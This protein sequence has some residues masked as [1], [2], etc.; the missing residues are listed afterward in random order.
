MPYTALVFFTRKPG[1]SPKEFQ[2]YFENNQVPFLKQSAGDAFPVSH[3]RIYIKRSEE[4]DNPAEV[5]VGS[6]DQ[7]NF[8]GIALM[9]FEDAADGKR[10]TDATHQPETL[11]KFENNP[12]LPDRTKARAVVV[13]QIYVTKRSD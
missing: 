2:H 8:D 7:F 10:F 9:E 1:T 11:A 6:Q 3:T 12:N 5:L 13:D 4:G